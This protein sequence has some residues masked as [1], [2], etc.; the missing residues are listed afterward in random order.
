MDHGTPWWNW[1][2]FR[3]IPLAVDDAARHPAVLVGHTASPD[4]G[5]HG[6]ILVRGVETQGKVE[7]FHGSL[8]R[9]LDRRGGLDK[10]PQEWLDSY[11]H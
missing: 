2:S 9:A 6:P 7:R 11:S 1:Q 3:A 5:P 8:Q 4:R 10:E